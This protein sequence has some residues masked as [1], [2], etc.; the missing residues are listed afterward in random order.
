M[1]GIAAGYYAKSGVAVEQARGAPMMLQANFTVV[2]DH[3]AFVDD[4]HR[5][6]P[7][8]SHVPG[9]EWKLWSYDA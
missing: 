6:A 3:A 5:F 7:F 2:Q 8:L 4:I 1:R 9:L